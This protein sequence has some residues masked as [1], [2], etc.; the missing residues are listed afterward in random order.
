MNIIIQNRNF[1]HT[2]SLDEFV[3][4]KFTKIERHNNYIEKIEIILSVDKLQNRA[5]A[6]VHIKNHDIFADSSTDNMYTSIDKLM[7]KIDKLLIKYKE[8]NNR[9]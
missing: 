3:R 2:E 7:H 8:K 9:S 5:E 1:D 6:K 4:N